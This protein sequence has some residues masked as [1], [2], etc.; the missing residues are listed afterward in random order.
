[1]G[2]NFTG[3]LLQYKSIMAELILPQAILHFKAIKFDKY[4]R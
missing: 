3:D 1:M 2:V 4:Y